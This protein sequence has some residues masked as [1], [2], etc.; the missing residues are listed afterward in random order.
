[1]ENIRIFNGCEV[2]IVNSVTRVT[3]RITRL[4]EWCRTVIPSDGIF[5]SHR[6]TIILAQILL[7]ILKKIRSW[8]VYGHHYYYCSNSILNIKKTSIE[9]I[10]I[11]I[12]FIIIIFIIHSIIIAIKLFNAS[13]V[14]SNI[15]LCLLGYASILRSGTMG[16]INYIQSLLVSYSSSSTSS[17]SS[18]SR[19]HCIN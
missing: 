12:I 7:W 8:Q 19:W 6:T 17:S 18:P 10:I 15:S 11:I 1:M 9:I 5:N 16:N 3:V 2:R 4:A 13:I 14:F